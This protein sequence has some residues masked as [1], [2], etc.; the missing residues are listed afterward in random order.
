MT[1]PSG[2]ITVL[3]PKS[4]IAAGKSGVPVGKNGLPADKNAAPARKNAILAS[5]SVA[6]NAVP[7]V[8]SGH[9]PRKN[10]GNRAI[11][12]EN[13]GNGLFQPRINRMDTD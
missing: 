5:E 12:Q 2:R 4:A 10:G 1:A 3:L 7:A 13:L 9:L 6:R 8:K 11:L